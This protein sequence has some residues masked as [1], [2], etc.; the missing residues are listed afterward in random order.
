[1]TGSEAVAYIHSARGRGKKRGLE[2]ITE[3]MHRLG[4]PQDTLRFVHVVGTNGKGSTSTMI[5]RSLTAAGYRTGLFISPF[6]L[7]FRERIQIDGAMIPPQALG[8]VV[9]QVRTAAEAMA[10]E[11]RRPTEFELVCAAAF[12]WYA[13]RQ[14]DIVV[15][16]AGLGGGRDATNLI[17]TSVLAVICAIGLDHTELLGDTPAAIAR[18][19]C[20]ILRRGVPVVSYPAQED[21]ALAA[22]MEC[23]AAL[24]CRLILGNL[25]AVRVGEMSLTG[26]DL[27]YR[28]LS[29]HLPL[30]G[31]YQIAN[32]VTAIEALFAL[33]DAGWAVSD[34]AIVRGIG[35]AFFPAR[36]EVLARQ[37]DVILDGAHNP[38]G[39]AALSASLDGLIPGELTVLLGMMKDKDVAASLAQVLPHA[40][41][42]FTVEPEGNPRAMK[43]EDLAA[44]CRGWC[45]EAAAY[46]L[47]QREA[48]A[49]AYDT[50]R[51]GETL[52]ICGSLYVA[53]DLRRVAGDFFRERGIPHSPHLD[54]P[55]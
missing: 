23:A 40:R 39:A 41:R 42:V 16:E 44:L 20:G 36:M 22:I 53:S 24:D 51:P 13:G 37:P 10:A 31:R 28:G 8:E 35:S 27:C 9:E 30:V 4:D 1:M 29:L 14:C 18:E 52:L 32:C 12:L 43:A 45:P 2:G 49:E 50:L 34:A 17:R 55:V 25:S 21:E 15:L 48:F 33:R 7:D 3:L 54:D 6:I 26:T 11:G 47:R 46:G 19:K 5:A 38:H